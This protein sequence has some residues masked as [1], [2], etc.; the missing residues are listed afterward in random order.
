MSTIFIRF[1]IFLLVAFGLLLISLA[2]YSGPVSEVTTIKA[3]RGLK[4]ESLVAKGTIVPD[5]EHELRAKTE[6]YLEGFNKRVG[7]QVKKGELL[8]RIMNQ[9]TNIYALEITQLESS[10]LTRKVERKIAREN[11]QRLKNGFD[12]GVVPGNEVL[13]ARQKLELADASVTSVRRELNSVRHLDQYRE[14]NSA[15]D[16]DLKSLARGVLTERYVSDGEWIEKGKLLG[17]VVTVDKLKIKAH[18][19]PDDVLN[20]HAGIK[21]K[22]FTSSIDDSWLEEILQVS[23]IISKTQE[24]NHLQEVVI[25]NNDAPYQL[26]VNTRVD[27]A[28]QNTDSSN[29]VVLPLDAIFKNK[30]VY[31]VLVLDEKDYLTFGDILANRGLWSSLQYAACYLSPCKTKFVRMLPYKVEIG[32]SNLNHVEIL[33]GI[34]EGGEVVLP[35]IASRKLGIVTVE[36]H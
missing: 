10:Q 19:L 11:Y 18:L 23:P 33:Q 25:S 34:D 14:K 8:G 36:R 5:L 27:L 26:R 3:E 16:S 4:G 32:S 22:V 29:K 2:Y 7:D 28:F 35:N 1:F 30:G 6:G 21:V 24:N 9:N 15:R 20:L 17:K 12:Q 31:Q 13:Q